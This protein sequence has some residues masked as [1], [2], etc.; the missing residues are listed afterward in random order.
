M[1]GLFITLEG[2]DGAG[3]SS[4]IDWL[5]QQFVQQGRQVVRT[6][7]PGG[8]PVAEQLRQLVLNEDMS[9]LSELLLVF[10]ARDDHLKKVILPSLAAGK[11]VLCDRFTDSTIAY[12]GYGRGVSLNVIQQFKDLIQK[13]LE[14]DIT[15]VFDIDP[16]IANERMAASRTHKDRFEQEALDFFNKVR[17]GFIKQSQTSARYCLIDSSQSMDVI[18]QQLWQKVVSL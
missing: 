7:E 18:R 4:H 14:P 15:F 1:S 11:V 16:M 10:A 12:Q 13:G 2:I 9:D 17:H 3:K 5:E 8:T 6:R